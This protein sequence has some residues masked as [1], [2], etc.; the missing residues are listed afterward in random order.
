MWPS[1]F[2]HS[3]PASLIT[4][5][6][7]TGTVAWT[8]LPRRGSRSALSSSTAFTPLMR[9]CVSFDDGMLMLS[10]SSAGTQSPST[11]QS[12]RPRELTSSASDSR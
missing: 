11:S 7:F 5:N 6:G 12:T 4:V 8:M 2:A 3:A 1:A 10:T 9:K